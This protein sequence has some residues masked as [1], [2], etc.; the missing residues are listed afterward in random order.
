MPISPAVNAWMQNMNGGSGSAQ[1]ADAEQLFKKSFSDMAFN[2]LRAKAQDLIPYVVTFTCF[3]SDVDN[4][5]AFGAFAVTYG[6]DLIYIPVVMTGGSVTSCEMAYLRKE[7]RFVPLLADF[8]KSVVNANTSTQA[9]PLTGDVHVDDTRTLFRNLI[10]PPS[11]SNVVFAAGHADIADLPNTAKQAVS[12][13]LENH[14]AL[15]GKIAE[16][17][18]VESLA[19]KLAKAPETKE[20][21]PVPEIIKISDLTKTA[22][23]YLT[24]SEQSEVLEKGYIVKGASETKIALDADEVSPKIIEER[25]YL[26]IYPSRRSFYNETP[27]QHDNFMSDP[28]SCTEC[29]KVGQRKGGDCI[30]SGSI[31]CAGMEGISYKD[32]IL[33]EDGFICD[34]KA[35]FGLYTEYSP[36]VIRNLGQ[37]TKADLLSQGFVPSSSLSQKINS[38][39]DKKGSIH[40]ICVVPRSNGT[41]STACKTHLCDFSLAK[42]NGEY[43]FRDGSSKQVLIISDK[44]TYGSVKWQGTIAVPDTALFLLNA[45]AVSDGNYD[46]VAGA[47]HSIPEIQ[48]H[49]SSLGTKLKVT[50]D[51]GSVN[52]TPSNTEKTAS[53]SSEADAAEWLHSNYQLTGS[54]ISDTLGRRNTLVIT[55]FAAESPMAVQQMPQ[56][57]PQQY[58]QQG[59]SETPVQSFN[60][61]NLETFANIGDQQVMDTGILSSFA[62]DPDVKG[63]LVDYMPDFMTVLD[64]VGRVVLLFCIK[65]REF[66]NYYRQDKL[67]ELLS[68]CRRVFKLVGG[69]VQDL[70]VYINMAK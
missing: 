50:R 34:K 54:Q 5:D 36:F 11:S 70:K 31:V 35:H 59:I 33:F 9:K 4:G 14:P 53:F 68:N 29:N 3:E 55:K 32:A 45:D 19:E 30:K 51:S 56:P 40:L 62:D 61:Q 23:Q 37:A 49:I 25:L 2:N 66:E 38:F 41:W 1:G 52:I 57:V 27:S 58:A 18:P 12:T 47:V 20:Y 8:I 69:L 39:G 17:Y 21:T 48:R 7:D 46:G 60:P 15:L 24:K 10:R 44:L 26:T 16:F 28:S 13:Y 43:I 64:R 65:K 6:R 22:A 42:E 67:E 63:L